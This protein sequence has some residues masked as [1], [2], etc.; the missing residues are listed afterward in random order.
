[1]SSCLNTLSAPQIYF[2]PGNEF[3]IVVGGLK[4]A[5]K[6]LVLLPSRD[7]GVWSHCAGTG[8]TEML[9]SMGLIKREDMPVSGPKA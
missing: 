4:M 9:Q 5:T 7:V 1:M 6:S 2:S 8:G 3:L